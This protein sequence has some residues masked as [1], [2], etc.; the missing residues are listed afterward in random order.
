MPF[1][2]DKSNA[3]S[4]GS[5]FLS[6]YEPACFYREFLYQ[7]LLSDAKHSSINAKTVH[8]HFTPARSLPTSS[9]PHNFTPAQLHSRTTSLPYNL[10][11][12]N[13]WNFTPDAKLYRE[14][15][16]TGVKLSGAK[17]YGSEV[18]GTEVVRE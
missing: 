2:G 3:G 10:A 14:R 1:L 6:L 18:G 9:L 15:S 13:S 17:L 11:P 16:C 7:L 12:D 5:Y 4:S 8:R